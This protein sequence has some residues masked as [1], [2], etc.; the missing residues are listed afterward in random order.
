MIRNN[1][2]N[3]LFLFT[4]LIVAITLNIIASIYFLLI[5]LSGILFMA[6][7]VALKRKYFYSLFFIIITFLIIEVNSGLKPLSLTML[8]LFLY[9]FIIPNIKRTISF[10]A[11]NSYL[12]IVIFYIGVLILWSINTDITTELFNAVIFNIL[13]DLLFFGLFI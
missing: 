9:I 3:P 1:L 4:L 13:I 8:S 2:D 6:F 11:I 5:M 12:Y 7:Y 10:S